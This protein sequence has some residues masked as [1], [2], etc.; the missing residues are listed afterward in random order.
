MSKTTTMETV[1]GRKS[2][3]PLLIA[4]ALAVFGVSAML[5]VNHAL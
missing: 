5:I 1:D 4:I 2:V 3:W